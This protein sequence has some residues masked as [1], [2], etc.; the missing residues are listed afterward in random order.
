MK[1]A[2]DTPLSFVRGHADKKTG[3][4]A[5]I[6]EYHF[7]PD[8]VAADDWKDG[9]ERLLELLRLAVNAGRLARVEQHARDGALPA[10]DHDEALL[11]KCR[12]FAMP[13]HSS[14]RLGSRR[15]PYSW[16]PPQLLILRSESEMLAVLPCEI[17]GQSIE[18]AAS[19]QAILRGRLGR[20]SLRGH[21][22]T[23]VHIRG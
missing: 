20:P 18:I 13:R 10:N 19:L 22:P 12:W 7:V 3:P 1:L 15:Y 8:V 17:E 5:A 23:A 11:K 4:T 2:E 14:M 21:E 16:F 6:A 9:H